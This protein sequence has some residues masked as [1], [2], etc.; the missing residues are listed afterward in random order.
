MSTSNFNR[1]NVERTLQAN[2][3]RT[4]EV[5]SGAGSINNLEVDN[6]DVNN[7]D[8]YD[9]ETTNLKATLVDSEYISNN[10]ISSN[11]AN[12][13][14]L[15]V[16]N[17]IA[18]N[19]DIYSISFT[20]FSA[21]YLYVTNISA[22]N[23]TVSNLEFVST[24][25]DNLNANTIN[26]NNSLTIGGQNRLIM[27]PKISIGS[28]NNGGMDQE[29][30]SI[31]IGQNTGVNNQRQNSIAI[32]N[33]TGNDNQ[34]ENS[35]SIG[36]NAGSLNQGINS[37]A[38]GSNAGYTNQREYSIAIGYQAGYDIQN[39]NAIAIGY[40]AGYTSQQLNTVAIG[41]RAG[42]SGQTSSAV[43]IGYQAGYSGQK[44]NS[45]AIGNLAGNLNQDGAGIAI[46]NRAGFINQR[47]NAIAI[48]NQAGSN[49]QNSEAIAIGSLAG[50]SGQG[51]LSI[52]IGRS[53]GAN[54]QK[55]ESVAIG[56]VAGESSQDLYSV[57]V[58]SRAGRYSQ[59]SGTVAIGFR[60][61]NTGQGTY[62][63][64]IGFESAYTRQSRDSIAI[65]YRAGGSDQSQ[66]AI[67]F[68]YEAGSVN[69]GVN[70]IAI[71]YQAGSDNQI[72]NSIAIGYQAGI[73]KQKQNAV[74]IGYQ[75]G[76]TGQGVNSVAIGYQS[77]NSNQGSNAVAIGNQ[78]GYFNQFGTSIAIGYE[79]GYT[80]QN[81]SSIAIGYQ[82]GREN[83]GTSSIAIGYQAGLTNPNNT[84][85][86]IILNAVSGTNL[87]ATTS[88]AF[89]VKPIRNL[90]VSNMLFYDPTSGEITYNVPNLG[91][92][93]PN[94][95]AYSN[96]AFWNGTSW[97]VDGN[98][99]HIGSLSGLSNQETNSIAIG[100]NAGTTRQLFNSV[101][102]GDGAG[103]L[104]QSSS[105]IAIGYQAG[106]NTQSQTAIAIGNQAGANNQKPNTVAIGN[107][108]GNLNQLANSI[109]IGFNSGMN[110][111]SQSSIAIGWSAGSNTQSTLAI[112]IGS[113]AGLLNQASNTIAI[114]WFAQG[115]NSNP[116]AI[117]IGRNAGRN[118]QGANSIAIGRDAGATSQH[119][120]SIVIN[121]QGTTLNTATS[122]SLYVKPIRLSNTPSTLFYDPTTGEISYD[123]KT[124]I[125]PNATNYSDYIFWNNNTSKWEVGNTTVHIGANS[126]QTNQG[127]NSIAIGELA[128]NLSQSSR[129]VAIGYLAG[130]LSQSGGSI[131]IGYTAGNSR[132]GTLSIAIGYQAGNASQSSNSIAIGNE[133][134]YTN[135]SR[136]AIAIGNEAGYK[137]QGSYSI[138]IGN[139]I[140]FTSAQPSKSIILNANETELN[141]TTSDAFYVKPIR[142]VSVSNILF[143]D[144]SSG[145]ISYDNSTKAAIAIPNGSQYSQYLYWD[146]ATSAW[147]VDGDKIHLGTN[148]GL[149]TQGS[150]TIAIGN[151]AGNTN[152]STGGLAIGYQAGGTG[153][154]QNSIAIGIQ[155]GS[156]TQKSHAVA[157]GFQAGFTN[158]NSNAISIGNQAGYTNQDYNSIAIGS[159]AGNLS[160]STFSIA[161]G[162][163]AGEVRQ[164]S[165]A[166]AIGYKAGS[167]TQKINSIAIG[168]EAGFTNQG[169]Y[170]IAIGNKAGSTNQPNNSIILNAFS[171][172]LAGQTI[173]NA[174][175]VNPVRLNDTNDVLFYNTSTGEISRGAKT[176]IVPNATN[177]GEYLYWDNTTSFW[178]IGSDRLSLGK[179]SGKINQGATTIAIGVEAGNDG[180]RAGAI[181]MG[182]K[183]GNLSQGTRAIA[184][185]VEAGSNTQGTR[186]IAIGSLAGN[187]GQGSF[188]IAIGSKAGQTNQ[189][190]QSIILNATDVE[191]SPAT[192]DAFY[193]KPIRLNSTTN[194][195]FYNSSTGE[196]SYDNS[197]KS[198]PV[199]GTNYSDILYWDPVTSSWLVE[200][201]EVHI[202][203]N[204]GLSNQ[205]SFAVAIGN[206]AGINNQSE[207]AIAI[208]YQAGSNTQKN[209]TIAIGYQAGRL[210]QGSTTAT[211]Y[212]IA[213]GSNAGEIV[214]RA[215]SIAIGYQ[216]GNFSQSSN[217]I[218][219]GRQAGSNTQGLSAIAIGFLSQL[220]GTGNL[221]IAIGTDSGKV[222]QGNRCV[223]IGAFSQESLSTRETVSIGYES[224]RFSQQTNAIAIGAY[225][226]RTFQGSNTI[227]IG[228][229]SGNLNQN[230]NSIAI[231]YES[232]FTNQGTN[233]IALGYQAGQ[234]NQGSNA[235]AIGYLAGANT[236]PTN[237]IVL[238]AGTTALNGATAN[239]L[240][241]NP[242]RNS[243]APNFLMYNATNKE[244]VYTTNPN[245]ALLNTTTTY[246]VNQEVYGQTYKKDTINVE[247]S[248]YIKTSDIDANLDNYTNNDQI[249]TFGK[250]QRNMWLIGQSG[251][252]PNNI[253]ISYDG[254]NFNGSANQTLLNTSVNSIKYNGNIYV[255]GGQGT[256]GA[257]ITNGYAIIYSYDGL[258]WIEANSIGGNFSPK[259][260]A[261]IYSVEYNDKIWVAVGKYLDFYDLLGPYIV[262]SYDGINWVDS[263]ISN[264]TKITYE[265][266]KVKWNGKLFVA[267]GKRGQDSAWPIIYS[268]DG[269]NWNDTPTSGDGFASGG[270]YD[271]HW[272]G[273]LFIVGGDTGGNEG[274][275]WSLD[276]IN[277]NTRLVVSIGTVRAVCSNG[278]LTVAAGSTGIFAYSYTV[279]TGASWT[280]VTTISGF[281]PM[282]IKWNGTMFIAV[283][284]NRYAI[285]RDGISWIAYT[286]GNNTTCIEYTNDR[287]NYIKSPA[288]LTVAA[289][290]GDTL[291]SYS[292]DGINF[293]NTQYYLQSLN[294]VIFN[295]NKSHTSTSYP[296]MY[297]AIGSG[298][299][300]NLLISNNY[301]NWTRTNI[302]ATGIYNTV[303][304]NNSGTYL[305]GI[306]PTNTTR[307]ILRSIDNAITWSEI[308]TPRITSS[309]NK[310]AFTSNGQGVVAVGSGTTTIAYSTNQ[311]S[312]W[313]SVTGNNS[314]T[315]VG[316]DVILASGSEFIAAGNDNI[317]KTNN[318][319]TGTWYNLTNTTQVMEYNQ[320]GIT[321][322]YST[323]NNI[324]VVCSIDTFDLN[325]TSNKVMNT[326]I[327]SL[328]NWSN[329]TMPENGIQF[330]KVYQYPLDNNMYILGNRVVP[331]NYTSIFRSTNGGLNFSLLTPTYSSGFYIEGATFPIVGE[332]VIF[333]GRNLST[334]SN[335]LATIPLSTLASGGTFTFTSL[336]AISRI[337]KIEYGT[338]IRYVAAVS[339]VSSNIGIYTSTNGS[340]TYNVGN[341]TVKIRTG[342]DVVYDGPTGNKIFVA[343]GIPQISLNITIQ[344]STNGLQWGDPIGTNIFTESYGV[345]F[346]PNIGTSGRWVAIG[347]GPN[348][349]I[350][351]S[352]DNASNWT[353]VSSLIFDSTSSKNIYSISYG[354]NIFVATGRISNTDYSYQIAYSPDGIAW[355]YVSREFFTLGYGNILSNIGNNVLAHGFETTDTTR[356]LLYSPDATNFTPVTANVSMSNILTI[357][358]SGNRFVMGGSDSE[359]TLVYSTSSAASSWVGLGKTIFNHSCTN[360]TWNGS[361][362]IA[363]GDGTKTAE[364]T[365]GIN[366]SL[367]PNIGL[368]NSQAK[369]VATDGDKW[370]AVGGNSASIA[371]SYDG[372]EN[373]YNLPNSLQIVSNT[374]NINY[375]NNKWF[376]CASGT[377]NLIQSDNGIIW[378]DVSISTL[379]NTNNIEYNGSIYVAVGGDPNSNSTIAYSSDGITWTGIGK[380]IFTQKGLN[381]KYNGNLFVAIGSGTN[382]LAYSY[383]G[384]SWF[385]INQSNL[386]DTTA[387][388]YNQSIWTVLA[389]STNNLG[390]S[391][392]GIN[393]ESTSTSSI[394]ANAGKDVT[395]N[396]KMFVASDNR[397]GLT[398]TSG[399]AYSY[400]AIE[401][402]KVNNSSLG[403]NGLNSNFNKTLV[404]IKHPMV[405]GFALNGT[406]NQNTLAYS[407]DG[408][409]WNGLGKSIFTTT[410]NSVN[411]NGDKWVAVGAGTNSIAYSYDAINWTGLGTPSSL[412]TGNGVIY[413][414]K[415]LA[416]GTGT[417]LRLILNSTNGINW[418]SVS[419]NDIFTTI[420]N[421]LSWNGS[422]TVAG[423]NGTN[424]LAYSNDGGLSW[425]AVANS[426]GTTVNNI[427]SN[428]C[429]DIMHDG[430]KF[431]AGGDYTGTTNNSNTLA[432]SYDGINWNRIENSK[433]LLRTCRT[434]AYNGS[435]YVAGGNRINTNF[436]RII[437]SYDGLNWIGP[438]T[439]SSDTISSITWV[440]DK[441]V[442]VGGTGFD[443]VDNKIYYSQDGINWYNNTV[444]SSGTL[445]KS[446]A[447][448]YVASNY[449]P[450]V[451]KYNSQLTINSN[452]PG[453]TNRLDISSGAYYD[454]TY[455]NFSVNIKTHKY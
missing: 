90:S 374:N 168:F 306:D 371:Y 245:Q 372:K 93:L 232:G 28:T 74:A 194:I 291:F 282:G 205:Q 368:F 271:I 174:F 80:S 20:N 207:S 385:G 235:I 225:S 317:K 26:I 448:R 76:G 409:Y 178:T 365:D 276:G 167:N 296:S 123:A 40:Q 332:D 120:N 100:I 98:K 163:N 316:Y 309:T 9:I 21:S 65:G 224:A 109:A 54:L 439:D 46:G 38:L 116:D 434:I 367:L 362:F 8:A 355:S 218:A 279:T 421:K 25:V 69:Q 52:A 301:T 219:I 376:I 214:Q 415:W 329:T 438:P 75:A 127:A 351:Y 236:Q 78:A 106:S 239:A 143:Y 188:S 85:Q 449:A 32:G 431:I 175:Y 160:Q 420:V 350:A 162:S 298:T 51:T 453:Q 334:Q 349:T 132:Q 16:E 203:T 393:W 88:T 208:G 87:T 128:G 17:F 297:V 180:Q 4:N 247:N 45:V 99:V 197:T 166:I 112:A 165:N 424:A 49:T 159:F 429:L 164:Q 292:Y 186:A 102:I 363:T 193:V 43:A 206:Q 126:G 400:D 155:A 345:A 89:Y 293:T 115:T 249:Y 2:R 380:T 200:G 356:K 33:N 347:R 68:G 30:G 265:I 242:I 139:K 12:I 18:E 217:A 220:S 212:S 125:I 370:I 287:L 366:W 137:Q 135:Q 14:L 455:T 286:L 269:I 23:I 253:K 133:A 211:P 216:A 344:S 263:N 264:I 443:V 377:R 131:A 444:P 86:T 117:A 152:Q 258:N 360:I 338:S 353:G 10:I 311:G 161:I 277:W 24:S 63:I 251:A 408:I 187:T 405:A 170:S 346:N 450:Q 266:R 238:N 267:V 189:P 61:G 198:G 395:W 386:T 430:V 50:F 381:V 383:N 130:Q 22:T 110:N 58:G 210:F 234:T 318:Y 103:N 359:N 243:D 308:A 397:I 310:F 41:Y 231:G 140:G 151:Q 417:S 37:I 328:S 31:A 48:G 145:E 416:C 337:Y 441:F 314:F 256:I 384:I 96:Y 124:N 230:E 149:S 262:Y 7:I 91:T 169:Q 237:S 157:I 339:P 290:S 202:G 104:S 114:G 425:T 84:I 190:S 240:Y 259:F 418:N 422:V 321:S 122:D 55:S 388:A 82:A 196:I 19:L 410:V 433:D 447:G 413:T 229:E 407:Y 375:I 67:A 111:Q 343:C 60:A 382:N 59:A 389:S 171:S 158:Q 92:I 223:A 233:S 336:T 327:T 358:S 195:L 113:Q 252:S 285:S 44:I 320:T 275:S 11:E 177:Y 228:F 325:N 257:I 281:Q 364:S 47:S 401:W 340:T 260:K 432:Y 379:T 295:N 148:A 307:T 222:S 70:T 101:A 312:T 13:K 399:N 445:L 35:I 134:G 244:I 215:N 333:Y 118:A 141:P 192:S 387:I 176:N 313:T 305:L 354:N 348:N 352:D 81:T 77:G 150:N 185:G 57:A 289:G 283:G 221:A 79:S 315:S 209:N 428:G 3:V 201:N 330:I 255:A 391:Y 414:D 403:I 284:N 241:V 303:S 105:S 402:T 322:A 34:G 226:G 326:L 254:Y 15:N 1:V 53:A 95:T 304:Y 412:T 411:W 335:V 250:S 213:I 440:G 278:I 6:L 273:S 183:A 64:S 147:K 153:Q 454:N 392:D 274:M 357:N 288:N 73:T 302:T 261:I 29:T 446:A 146:V 248:S 108:A 406:N 324:W 227:A 299:S 369:S 426:L 97:A 154:Q 404:N 246:N 172:E 436:G 442:A 182:N 323:I 5:I 121:A 56:Y 341:S 83:Q 427:F 107:Q 142:N 394:L 62:G 156:N 361:K 342:Y 191:L 331:A 39:S 36:Q 42:Y 204:A 181:S 373:W 173:A 294:S 27:E 129:A 199:N 300:N 138:A 179:D 94:G 268:Y 184:I 390:Y 319:T 378:K 423:G 437:Y 419:L 270:I 396:G 71:G 398:G 451:N 144:P 280:V 66:T 272:N 452:G 72:S 435:V 136:Y 119:A